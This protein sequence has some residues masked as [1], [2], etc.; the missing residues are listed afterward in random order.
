MAGPPGRVTT[1]TDG[2]RG[3]GSEVI[4][5]QN[6]GASEGGWLVLRTSPIEDCAGGSAPRT[7]A[8]TWPRVP[9]RDLWRPDRPSCTARGLRPSVAEAI[10][11]L[12][13][14]RYVRHRSRAG[15]PVRHGGGRLQ[16]LLPAG[17]PRTGSPP[18]EGRSACTGERA[19]RRRRPGR[20]PSS[21]GPAG[22]LRDDL[23]LFRA[24]ACGR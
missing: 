13:R 10:G 17:G 4:S 23:R 15:G 18:A 5:A 9:A 2:A 19:T 8:S 12:V 21:R 16:G 6:R 3:A 11:Q 22:R 24:F 7:L 14:P 20:F 1:R